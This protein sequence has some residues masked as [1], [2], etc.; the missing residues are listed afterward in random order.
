M[1]RSPLNL[2]RDTILYGAFPPLDIA[3]GRSLS[4][5]QRMELLVPYMDA[6][7]DVF[8]LHDYLV[9][10]SFDGDALHIP[11]WLILLAAIIPWLAL[12]GWRARRR[13]KRMTNAEVPNA[14]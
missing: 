5:D 12:L 9:A 10:R 7:A 13:K 6:E 4:N 2:G 11:H 8:S 3:R 1:N 14:G